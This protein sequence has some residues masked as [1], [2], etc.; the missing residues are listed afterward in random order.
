MLYILTNN[1]FNH[2]DIFL[3][4]SCWCSIS[5]FLCGCVCLV[6]APHIQCIWFVRS[7]RVYC[8]YRC[9]FC[10]A[11]I[12][13][14]PT[15]FRRSIGN[16]AQLLPTPIGDHV[17]LFRDHAQLNP[18]GTLCRA[19]REHRAELWWSTVQSFGGAPCRALMELPGELGAGL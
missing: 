3:F 18:S 16:H 10:M 4:A 9:A 17:Q 2:R 12:V 19:L 11:K 8:G 5:I 14:P 6:H 15:F 13:V 7:L 1:P